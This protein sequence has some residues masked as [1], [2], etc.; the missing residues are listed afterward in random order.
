[1]F[2]VTWGVLWHLHMFAVSFFINRIVYMLVAVS[3]S[4]MYV[5][6]FEDW[7][8][9][10]AHAFARHRLGCSCICCFNSSI[11]C[12]QELA[13][14]LLFSGCRTLLTLLST[15]TCTSFRSVSPFVIEFFHLQSPFSWL[16]ST[17]SIF[18]RN[19]LLQWVLY[20]LYDEQAVC[21]AMRM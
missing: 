6:L 20:G 15:T 9:E 16:F 21:F 8:T 3:L 1:M 14:S 5:F 11:V 2:A 12:D 13:D 17:I 18:I 7:S 10:Q 4:V 19:F